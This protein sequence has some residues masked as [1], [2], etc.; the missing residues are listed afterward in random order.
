M[1]LY[2]YFQ[3]CCTNEFY[4]RKILP[5]S[6]PFDTL[7]DKKFKERY[8]LSKPVV[9]RLL[10]EVNVNYQSIYYTTLITLGS[11]LTNKQKLR[12]GQGHGCTAADSRQ[13][14]RVWRRGH[15]IG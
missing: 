12:H 14:R 3:T 10:R 5:Q 8:R 7:D 15:V 1:I 6:N 13:A 9:V 2:D 4:D 11:N